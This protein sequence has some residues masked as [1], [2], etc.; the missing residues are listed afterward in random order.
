MVRQLF[1]KAGIYKTRFTN[2]G[3]HTLKVSYIK[4]Y[5]GTRW[6]DEAKIYNISLTPDLSLSLGSNGPDPLFSSCPL[7]TVY[8]GRNI[9]YSTT[10]SS[11]YSPFYRNTSL[12]SVKITDKETEISPNEFYGCT[13]L[14]N[15]YIGDGVTTIGDWAFSGC[16][17]LDFFAIGSSVETIGKEAF[18][19]CTAMT[20]FI[21][22]AQTPPTCGSQ[23]LDDINKWTCTLQ[24][25]NNS[26]LLYQAAPQW[27]DFFFIEDIP[28]G[29]T[30]IERESKREDRVYDVDGRHLSRM[31][32]GINI[33][34]SSDGTTRKV[35]VR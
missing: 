35:L 4:D 12:R 8:I 24:V 15:V 31:Q 6:A 29:I 20:K 14:Q 19:D 27:K 17:S 34:K 9:S 33:I 16:S 21:S 18:S 10:S 32:K 13:N 23:A 11:G 2:P 5:S 22:N 1:M 7:D 30:F 26:I 28:T 25:P 3:S